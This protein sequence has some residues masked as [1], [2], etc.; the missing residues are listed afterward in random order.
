MWTLTCDT[1]RRQERLVRVKFL[2]EMPNGKSQDAWRMKF[3]QDLEAVLDICDN[4]GHHAPPL[5]DITRNRII[6]A[7]DEPARLKALGHA[8]WAEDKERA[9]YT[10]AEYIRGDNPKA[11]EH[12]QGLGACA[13]AELLKMW[14]ESES[15]ER[16]FAR[17]FDL[18]LDGAFS[19]FY[20]GV[21][22]TNMTWPWFAQD[23]ARRLPTLIGFSEEESLLLQDPSNC[24]PMETSHPEWHLKV[25][26]FVIKRVKFVWATAGMAFTPHETLKYGIGVCFDYSN[27]TCSLLAL[28]GP[29]DGEPKVVVGLK[30]AND[31]DS[32][33]AWIE[34]R[35][36]QYEPQAAIEIGPEYKPWYSYGGD[37]SS[38]TQLDPSASMEKTANF[39]ASL[40]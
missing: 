14:R 35:G 36:I 2:R 20:D 19:W 32:H 23:Q 22:R 10:L 3:R 13:A 39:I 8:P 24:P 15:F 29:K 37:P 21:H 34:W 18:N 6:F 17:K 5:D 11:N 26:H 9:E 30:D 12:C 28:F 16:S 25:M 4:P 7:R 31:P 33:H 27:L 38:F 1:D 40:G